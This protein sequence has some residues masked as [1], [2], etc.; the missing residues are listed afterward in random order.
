MLNTFYDILFSHGPDCPAHQCL[1]AVLPIAHELL[2]PQLLELAL[3]LG[4]SELDGVELWA[5]HHVEDVLEAEL[6]HLLGGAL[7][8]T[9][10]IHEQAQ[11]FAWVLLLQLLQ[12][13]LEPRGVDGLGEDLEVLEALLLRDGGQQRQGRLAQPLLVDSLVLLGQGPLHVHD[14]LAGEHGLI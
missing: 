12:V 7:V 1:M 10:V 3:Q 14:S 9:E 5:V 13:L 4:E 6:L 8:H 2:G 11:L